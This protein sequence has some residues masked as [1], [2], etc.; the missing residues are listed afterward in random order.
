[1]CFGSSSC[2]QLIRSA[3]AM[4]PISRIWHQQRVEQKN[5]KW[6]EKNYPQKESLGVDVNSFFC[7]IIMLSGFALTSSSLWGLG[8]HRV[9]LIGRGLSPVTDVLSL[10]VCSRLELE[11]NT[12]ARAMTDLRRFQSRRGRACWVAA[13]KKGSTG[14]QRARKH[15]YEMINLWMMLRSSI[16]FST[17]L[18]APLT[19][20]R[21]AK[22][23]CP[24]FLPPPP[25]VLGVPKKPTRKSI[26]DICGA[27]CVRFLSL[28]ID[29]DERKTRKRGACLN[30]FRE[31][32]E[33]DKFQN[34]LLK[35]RPPALAH[36]EELGKKIQLRIETINFYQT[37]AENLVRPM[38]G[39]AFRLL[40]SER[41]VSPESK[42]TFHLM[43]AAFGFAS[44]ASRIF[45][46]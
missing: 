5:T 10:A 22:N 16:L 40:V 17:V 37:F 27:M 39:E 8:K 31:Q 43:H 18:C 20:L 26:A 42:F 46:R 3:V 33:I 28:P 6:K 19:H 45:Y 11:I 2:L 32:L 9:C 13:K 36:R 34:C 23:C 29:S 44:I 4:N 24:L 7:W 12:Q 30:I 25:E 38:A 21:D 14:T 41:K 35:R 1:M 15:Q